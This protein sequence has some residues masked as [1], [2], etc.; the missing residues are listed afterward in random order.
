MPPEVGS[1]LALI[2]LFSFFVC[3]A[4]NASL[5]ASA[6]YFYPEPSQ[7][8]LRQPAWCPDI[9]VWPIEGRLIFTY[10]NNVFL[11]GLFLMNEYTVKYTWCSDHLSIGISYPSEPTRHPHLIAGTGRISRNLSGALS[12]PGAN[13]APILQRC[14]LARH[15][16]RPSR[17][18]T[19]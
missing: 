17:M 19:S 5:Q 12:S 7:S 3:S 9:D 14:L 18:S 13:A 4:C 16:G 15:S 11:F 10:Q 1:I 6:S 2:I 8:A